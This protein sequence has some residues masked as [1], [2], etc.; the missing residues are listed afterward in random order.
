MPIALWLWPLP[1]RIN[2]RKISIRN[3]LGFPLGKFCSWETPLGQDSLFLELTK[4]IKERDDARLNLRRHNRYRWAFYLCFTMI[5]KWCIFMIYRNLEPVLQEIQQQ[6]SRQR[7]GPH[8]KRKWWLSARRDL[9]RLRGHEVRRL[10]SSCPHSSKSTVS[11]PIDVSKF[12][13]RVDNFRAGAI[14]KCFEKFRIRNYITCKFYEYGFY[15]TL[16]PIAKII[17]LMS[18]LIF[19]NWI[20][21]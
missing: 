8:R 9:L 5:E 17:Q 18:Y 15:S 3:A 19:V 21:S 4:K 20:G 7:Q 11:M 12:K 13:H 6:R 2:W 10:V 14:K 16:F 1:R